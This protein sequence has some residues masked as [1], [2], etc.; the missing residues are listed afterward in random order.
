MNYSYF[1]SCPRSEPGVRPHHHFSVP[2]RCY[3]MALVMLWLVL[4]LLTLHTNEQVHYA[5]E[6]TK[7]KGQP[8]EI[9][10]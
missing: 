1:G 6:L 4:A 10:R 8:P 5:L 9:M 3:V 2:V 7:L